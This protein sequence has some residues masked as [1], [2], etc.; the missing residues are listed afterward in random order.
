MWH[1][2]IPGPATSPPQELL[3]P[4]M[5]QVPLNCCL[6]TVSSSGGTVNCSEGSIVES[7]ES[8]EGRNLFAG[9]GEVEGLGV[10]GFEGRP[11]GIGRYL[12]L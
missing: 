9:D 8:S 3:N 11:E 7:I 1:V 2:S 6:T 12:K 10:A 4:V 5:T